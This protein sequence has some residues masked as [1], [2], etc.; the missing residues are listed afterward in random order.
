[1]TILKIIKF[2]AFILLTGVGI[3]TA[4]A[5]NSDVSLSEPN[6]VS[7]DAEQ[8]KI[9]SKSSQD[10]YTFTLFNFFYTES[11]STS[12]SSTTVS[13]ELDEVEPI[14]DSKIGL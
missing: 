14:D 4:S 10:K 9:K 12:D 6:L 11:R 8:D 3:S 7:S 5:V 1:M 13:T 2:I